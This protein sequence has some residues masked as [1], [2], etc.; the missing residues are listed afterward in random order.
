MTSRNTRGKKRLSETPYLSKHEEARSR[1]SRGK[2]K[3]V[4]NEELVGVNDEASPTEIALAEGTIGKTIHLS[5]EKEV[6]SKSFSSIVHTDSVGQTLRDEVS[7]P[8]LET[9]CSPLSRRESSSF[10]FR[11]EPIIGD[12]AKSSSH[13][14]FSYIIYEP[15]RFVIFIAF[16]FGS[17]LVFADFQVLSKQ[18]ARKITSLLFLFFFL[19]VLY[20]SS[21]RRNPSGVNQSDIYDWE[22]SLKS[23]RKGLIEKIDAIDIEVIKK[24]LE[25]LRQGLNEAKLNIVE[26]K[27]KRGEL[28]SDIEKVY[29]F[30]KRPRTDLD[31]LKKDLLELNSQIEKWNE[32]KS[33]IEQKL[34]SSIEVS[35]LKTIEHKWEEF[36]EKLSERI[37]SDNSK[38][39]SVSSEDLLASVRL[40]VNEIFLELEAQLKEYLK[41]E[42]SQHKTSQGKIDGLSLLEDHRNVIEQW[43]SIAIQKE[44]EAHLFSSKPLS[45]IVDDQQLV[46]TIRF[47]V[48]EYFAKDRF[49]GMADYALESAGASIISKRTSPSYQPPS[50]NFLSKLFPFNRFIPKG[51]PPESILQPDISPG[52]CWAFPGT[53][54]NVTIRLAQQVIPSNF[55]L[56]HI[57]ESIAF[58]ISSC[59]KDFSVYG[60]KS[61]ND[62]NPEML[63][64]YVYELHKHKTIQ[65]FSAL[66]SKNNVYSYIQLRI[67][68]NYGNPE[69]TCVYRFRVHGLPSNYGSNGN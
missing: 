37:S 43:I 32:E 25:Q 23:L 58:N 46:S 4:M 64:Q 63:G 5:E 39:E 40:T 38:Q 20:A 28:Q 21:T 7:K 59:P 48:D 42:L 45:G 65:T 54:G 31:S 56:E 29:D 14:I 19:I 53:K 61:A 47:A 34:T 2:S 52:N 1:S 17:M 10:L 8:T 50:R 60:M 12:K 33:S 24:D 22:E 68:S 69:F 55:T 66:N 13:G 44:L 51:N 62:M 15:I 36:K 67:L 6:V 27:S 3:S 41:A 26:E 16:S 9:S 57:S 30:A 49:I 35:I 11:A 18:S